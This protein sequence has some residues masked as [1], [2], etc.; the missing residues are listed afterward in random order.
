MSQ[1]NVEAVR[2]ILDAWT[3]GDLIPGLRQSPSRGGCGPRP[4]GIESG[5]P[6][7][8]TAIAAFMV[9]FREP[10]ES[11]TVDA[12]T[13]P[14]LATKSSLCLAVQHGVGKRRR[15]EEAARLAV[16]SRR[17]DHPDRARTGK[18]ERSPRSRGAVGVGDV[19]GERGDRPRGVGCVE[20]TRHGRALRVLRSRGRVGH[21]PLGRPGHG[22]LPQA[23]KE[24]RT[25]SVSGRHS[26]S[27]ST[28][29][30]RSTPT[31]GDA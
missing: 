5:E 4:P 11:F 25:S 3:S 21:D 23:T 24:F 18:R 29:N 9:A 12:I 10:W 8:T 30:P 27:S 6:S 26:S 1:E 14:K 28:P 15:R 22:G 7:V 17:Q 31:P 2:A 16:R 20:P 19:A 13:V